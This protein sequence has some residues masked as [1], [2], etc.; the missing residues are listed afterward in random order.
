VPVTEDAVLLVGAVRVKNAN[1]GGP[2]GRYAGTG[3][4]NEAVGNYD[5]VHGT[6]SDQLGV[7]VARPTN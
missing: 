7:T 5:P 3:A 1:P 6:L 4:L 2:A